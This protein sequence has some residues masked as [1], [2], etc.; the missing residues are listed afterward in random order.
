MPFE[1]DRL[2]RNKIFSDGLLT[3]T[4][5]DPYLKWAPFVCLLIP[6]TRRLK[7]RHSFKERFFVALICEGIQAAI[8]QSFKKNLDELRPQPSL[9]TQSFPSGHAATSFA[10]AELLRSEFSN[11]HPVACYSGYAMAVAVSALRLCNNKHW[12]SDVLVGAAIGVISARLSIVIL[13]KSKQKMQRHSNKERATR[14][15]IIY[16]ENL[17]HTV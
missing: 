9:S 15:K 3:N 6:S 8:T 2:T 10:G 1:I 17:Q 13:N 5:L 11:E 16:V 12:L 4:H 7:F 14:N